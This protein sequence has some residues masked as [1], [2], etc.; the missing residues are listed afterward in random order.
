MSRA[1][2][3]GCIEK[4]LCL[5]DKWK[6]FNSLFFKHMKK[7]QGPT[8]P[9]WIKND[10]LV[11]FEMGSACLGDEPMTISGDDDHQDIDV[12]ETFFYIV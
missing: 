2:S 6:L 1:H 11:F 12:F 8:C 10:N 3:S 7:F 5:S 4:C 9:P